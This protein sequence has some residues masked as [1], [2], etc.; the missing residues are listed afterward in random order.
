MIGR[1]IDGPRTDELSSIDNSGL[2]ETNTT[3]GNEELAAS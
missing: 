3:L 1:S 2:L